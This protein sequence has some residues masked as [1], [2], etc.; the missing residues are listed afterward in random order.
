MQTVVL[1]GPPLLDAIV[2][3]LMQRRIAVTQLHVKQSSERRASRGYRFCSCAPRVL[4]AGVRSAGGKRPDFSLLRGQGE[5]PSSGLSGNK[6]RGWFL[7]QMVDVHRAA[8]QP[9]N[10]PA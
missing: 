4:P 9:G 7:R 8:N 3:M 2:R 10:S 5:E 1:P 6:S